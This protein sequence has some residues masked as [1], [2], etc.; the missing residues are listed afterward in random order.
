MLQILTETEKVL[1]HKS[2]KKI[3][4]EVDKDKKQNDI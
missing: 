1:I 2:G 4:S 3:L